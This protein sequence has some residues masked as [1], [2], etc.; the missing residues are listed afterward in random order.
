MSTRYSSRYTSVAIALHWIIALLIGGM[1]WLGW[2]MHDDDHKAIVWMFQLHKSIGITVLILT[3]ARIL[4]R[5]KN[6]EPDLP[7]DIKPPERFLSAG[8]QFGF[9][10]LMLAMPLTGWLVVSTS[11]FNVATVLFGRVSWPHIP[12]AHSL[13]GETGHEILEFVHSKLAWLL[14]ALLALHVIG[15]IKHEFSGEE[16][17]MKRMLPGLFGKTAPPRAPSTGFFTAFGGAALL[18]GLIASSPLIAGAMGAKPPA[19]E[20]QTEGNWTVDAGASSI[21]FSGLNDGDDFSGTFE[22]WT[23]DINFDLDNLAAAHASV[24]VETGSANTG[25]K[26][27]DDTLKAAEWFSAVAFPTATVELTEFE[28]VGAGYAAQATLTVK[29]V[30]VSVPFKFTLDMTEDTA[31][32]NG[33]TLLSRAALNLGQDSDASGD[34]VSDEIT[35]TVSVTASRAASHDDDGHEH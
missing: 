12:F 35:V 14:I 8:V 24:I 31:V 21:T 22:D 30:G 10:G 3:V 27:N 13:F 1:I 23:A 4:W 9:Y 17:V 20:A 28:E 5:I 26:L 33:T 2:N 34:W 18:F 16:G 11:K 6:P 19:V 29:G 32:M 15:A 25:T 7:S